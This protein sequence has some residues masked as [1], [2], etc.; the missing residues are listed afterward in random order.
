[1]LRGSD[2]KSRDGGEEFLLLLQETPVQG[3]QRAAET[4]RRELAVH[5]VVWDGQPVA[6]SASFG[7]AT[8]H[9]GETSAETLIARA[10]AAL[11]RAK[12]EGRDCIRIAAE[13][14]TA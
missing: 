1:M 10:D 9:P 14:L 12:A 8:A 13:P 6:V 7:I 2:L 4:L 3:A 11:S 5:P